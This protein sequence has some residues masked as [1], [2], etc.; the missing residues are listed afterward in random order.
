MR[1]KDLDFCGEKDEVVFVDENVFVYISCRENLKLNKLYTQ[2]VHEFVYPIMCFIFCFWQVPFSFF[3]KT[4]M[5]R[6]FV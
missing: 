1:G 4:S 5:G 6:L 3:E 2:K